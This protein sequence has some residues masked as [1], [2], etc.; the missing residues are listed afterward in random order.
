LLKLSKALKEGRSHMT[1]VIGN[2]IMRRI[3]IPTDKI[4]I[5]MAEKHGFKHERTFYRRI[6]T[7]RIPWKNAPENIPGAKSETISSEAIIIWKY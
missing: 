1:F 6:P 2:R 3:R 5:E 4:L 7:K